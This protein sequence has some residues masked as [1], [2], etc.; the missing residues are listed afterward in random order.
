MRLSVSVT[1]SQL[2]DNKAAARL[3]SRTLYTMSLARCVQGPLQGWG[4]LSFP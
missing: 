4:L 1:L 3:T 2:H